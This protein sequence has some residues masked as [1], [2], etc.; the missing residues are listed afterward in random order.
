[1]IALNTLQYMFLCTSRLI[2]K[3]TYYVSISHNCT[4]MIAHCYRFRVLYTESTNRVTLLSD[5]FAVE[6]ISLLK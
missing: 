4:E 6:V 3:N 5:V 2:N 1:M